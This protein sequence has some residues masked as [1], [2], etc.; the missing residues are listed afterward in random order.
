MKKTKETKEG[1]N[2]HSNQNKSVCGFDNLGNG[3]D[4]SNMAIFSF[5]S[6]ASYVLIFNS[7]LC[8]V[9]LII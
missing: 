6:L 8:E 4:N 5:K 3:E 2:G 9:P 7:L 1:I